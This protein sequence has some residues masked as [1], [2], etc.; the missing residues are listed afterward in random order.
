MTADRRAALVENV[1]ALLNFECLYGASNAQIATAAIDLIR[2]DV[3]EE[4]AQKCL[5]MDGALNNAGACAVAIRALKGTT[6][7]FS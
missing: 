5:T 7:S 6:C 3:L 4:A 2:A 1:E